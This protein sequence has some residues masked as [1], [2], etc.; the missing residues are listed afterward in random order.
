MG[1]VVGGLLILAALAWFFFRRRKYQRVSAADGQ[2]PRPTTGG[3]V[4]LG[5]DYAQAE[6]GDKVVPF[7]SPLPTSSQQ[8]QQQQQPPMQQRESYGYNTSAYVLPTDQPGQQHP[9]QS[10]L[11]PSTTGDGAQNMGL[12]TIPLGYSSPSPSQS[13]SLSQSQ[14]QSQSQS[15]S[16]NA[17]GQSPT[18]PSA[19]GGVADASHGGTRNS[20]MMQEYL[21]QT[22]FLPPGAAP[23]TSPPPGAAPGAGQVGSDVSGAGRGVPSPH[24]P[25]SAGP[26]SHHD[27]M[28]QDDP[29]IILH[30]DGGAVPTHQ[31]EGA[32]GQR[33]RIELPP[34]YSQASGQQ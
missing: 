1:G 21:R 33:E 9:S 18:S 28:G 22:T 13:Q 20:K 6:E 32:Q 24:S 23:S 15:G 26:W 10:H 2:P 25:S 4:D 17:W 31:Q 34:T 8:Q 5:D 12:A 19:P 16:S 29:E 11:Y 27:P 7:P 14:S 30:Q 3:R